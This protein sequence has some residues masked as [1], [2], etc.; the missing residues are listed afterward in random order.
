M[1]VVRSGRDDLPAL[2]PGPMKGTA[3]G[4]K[5]MSLR[6]FEVL[7]IGKAVNI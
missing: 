1:H 4:W 7:T 5:R 3:G 2:H 6:D